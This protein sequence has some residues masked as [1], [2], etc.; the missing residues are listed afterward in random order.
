MV[1]FKFPYFFCETDAK[2]C[3]MY[4]TDIKRVC[5]EVIETGQNTYCT[6]VNKVL[7]IEILD[8]D[9]GKIYETLGH[10]MTRP[11]RFLFFSDRKKVLP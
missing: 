2:N 8:F 11:K 10:V 3:D 5:P 4:C 6:V 7:K 9:L 1:I